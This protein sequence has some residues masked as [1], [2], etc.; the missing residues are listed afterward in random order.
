MTFRDIPSP[1]EPVYETGSPAECL[2]EKSVL[3]NEEN[4]KITSISVFLAVLLLASACTPAAAP[5]QTNPIQGIVWQW[6]SLTDSSKGQT[7]PVPQPE[8][9]TIT[10]NTNGTVEGKADCNNFSG[11]YSQENGFSIKITTSTMAYCGDASLDQQYLKLLSEVAA[12]GP[13][14]AGGLAL[15]TAGGA[16][17]MLFKNGGA[18]K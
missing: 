3:M 9:Y 14:G 7:T 13:D 10:F 4:M 18:K 15:E 5:A 2:G 11:T 1:G 17:R 12:G 16:Q 6:T 8:N